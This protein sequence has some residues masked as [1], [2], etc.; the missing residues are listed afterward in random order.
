MWACKDVLGGGEVLSLK[1]CQVKNSFTKIFGVNGFLFLID[2]VV[3]NCGMDAVQTGQGAVFTKH[4]QSLMQ[5]WA[6]RRK[7]NCDTN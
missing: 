2:L 7:A 5:C 3:G 6:K 1:M 4:T